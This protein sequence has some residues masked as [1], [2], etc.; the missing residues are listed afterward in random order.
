MDVKYLNFICTKETFTGVMDASVVPFEAYENY[1]AIT[2]FYDGCPECRS[3]PK[4]EYFSGDWFK[5]WE[6]WVIWEN[7]VIAA[8]AGIWKI[9]EN[10]WEVAGV[11]TRPEYRQKGYSA[12]VVSHCVAR[13]LEAGKTAVLS[14]AKTNCAMIGVAKKAGFVLSESQDA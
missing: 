11:V 10:Q 6:D 7:G 9:D 4:E 13:I 2:A 3:F 5:S 8:R 14:T 1:E 12:R